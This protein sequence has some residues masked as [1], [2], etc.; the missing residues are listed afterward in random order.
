M[1]TPG[2]IAGRYDK[3][4][5]LTSEEELQAWEPT[6]VPGYVL[7]LNPYSNVFTTTNELG[8]TVVS[9]FGSVVGKYNNPFINST[10]SRMPILESGGWVAATSGIARPSLVFD[11]VNDYLE[12]AGDAGPILIGG[13]NKSFTIFVVAQ[14][15]T[16]T[17]LGILGPL[18]SAGNLANSAVSIWNLSQMTGAWWTQKRGDTGAL[19]SVTGGTTNT[20]KH[21]FMVAHSG[22]S[23]QLDVD[24][25]TVALG[26]QITGS[27]GSVSAM[28]LGK[29]TRTSGTTSLCNYR[30]ARVLGFNGVLGASDLA[31][32]RGKLA[33]IYF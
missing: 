20:S 16:L 14:L 1:R 31:Y 11:G 33:E 24:G 18:I 3:E 29:S 13:T 25:V 21:E 7:N 32:V 10:L 26:A 9:C 15:V 23:T 6:T 27:M 5:A 8:A 19:S 4:R 28:T 12:C 2:E 30:L 22:V 17:S